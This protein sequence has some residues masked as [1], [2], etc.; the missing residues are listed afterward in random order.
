MVF[1]RLIEKYKESAE[2]RELV[3][4]AE[5]KVSIRISGQSIF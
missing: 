5:H 4:P 1:G 3:E 2:F